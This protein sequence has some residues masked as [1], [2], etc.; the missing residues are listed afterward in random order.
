MRRIKLT[1]SDLYRMVDRSVRRILRESAYGKQ[2]QSGNKKKRYYKD[3]E[4]KNGELI[5]DADTDKVLYDLSSHAQVEDKLRELRKKNPNKK[6]K[7][8]SYC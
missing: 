8:H 1:E 4:V 6:Y 5:V 2:D 7:L 3:Y